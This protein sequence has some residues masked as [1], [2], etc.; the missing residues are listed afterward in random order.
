MTNEAKL[1]NTVATKQAPK[2][3]RRAVSLDRR[4]AR[5]GWLFVLPFVLGLVVM[6][7]PLLA[8]L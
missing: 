4:K 3:R 1:Q 2:K 6:Y 5:A 8:F 7:L